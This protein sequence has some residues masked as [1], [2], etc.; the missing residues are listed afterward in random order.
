ML[1][2]R[3]VLFSCNIGETMICFS[4]PSFDRFGSIVAFFQYSPI[5]ILSVCLPPSI[6][7]FSGHGEQTWIRKEASEV[8][9]TY[10]IFSGIFVSLEI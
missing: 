4:S 6:L 7:E 3:I 10:E 1:I 8:C 9:R 5:D 2:I